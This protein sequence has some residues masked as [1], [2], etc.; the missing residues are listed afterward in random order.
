MID[1]NYIFGLSLF[2]TSKLQEK[3][4]PLKFFF[5]TE[6]GIN[7]EKGSAKEIELKNIITDDTMKGFQLKNI[8]QGISIVQNTLQMLHY[9]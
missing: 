8:K 5:S 3:Y 1:V 7:S 6:M 2:S 4:Y 9:V